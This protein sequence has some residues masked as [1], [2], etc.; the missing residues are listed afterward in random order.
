[1]IYYYLKD[2]QGD[3]IGIINSNNEVIVKY[4]YDSFGNILSIKDSNGQIIT[5]TSNIGIINPFRYRG[6]YFDKETGLYYLNARYYNPIWGRFLNADCSISPNGD[7]QSYNLFTYCSNNPV[8]NK[9]TSGAIFF[10]SLFMRKVI[11][12]YTYK[13]EEEKEQKNYITIQTEKKKYSVEIDQRAI[14]VDLSNN[15]NGKIKDK[16]EI[17]AIAK[18]SYK[19]YNDI[20]KENLPG[21]TPEGLYSEIIHHQKM[22]EIFSFFTFTST[23]KKLYNHSIIADMGFFTED[24]KGSDP[25]AYSYEHMAMVRL[26]SECDVTYTENLEKAVKNRQS[27]YSNTI[28]PISFAGDEISY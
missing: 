23:G 19:A 1:M 13:I 14:H 16:C 8:S 5:D 27:K 4:E 7:F 9:D 15:G 21:R 11:K 26:P 3:I 17:Y 28:L 22:A 2:V 6:Y 20:Y 12:Y 10:F 24:G 25:D 18:A